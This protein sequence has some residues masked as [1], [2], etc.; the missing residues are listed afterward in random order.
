MENQNI[1]I[2]DHAGNQIRVIDIDG[3]AWFVSKDIESISGHN[4]IRYGL[5]IK[6]S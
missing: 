5:H 3:E 4:N 2:F 1:Q 6:R